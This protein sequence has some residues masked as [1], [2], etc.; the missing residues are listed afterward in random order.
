MTPTV[1]ILTDGRANIALDGTANRSAAG[2]DAYTMAKS[3]RSHA[4]D[5]LVID[6]SNRPQQALTRLSETLLAPYVP[7]PRA[8]AQRISSAVSAVLSD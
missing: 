4:I 1:A 3:L 6:M 8:D 7:L 5:C 2:E